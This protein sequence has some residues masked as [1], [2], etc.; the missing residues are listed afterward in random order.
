MYDV[1]SDNPS[2]PEQ[3]CCFSDQ[4]EFGGGSVLSTP[5]EGALSTQ[6][7]RVAKSTT[8]SDGAAKSTKTSKKSIFGLDLDE[9]EAVSFAMG[10]SPMDDAVGLPLGDDSA[11]SPNPTS[12]AAT[13]N[14]MTVYGLMKSG[15]MYAICPFIPHKSALSASILQNLHLLNTYAWKS[16]PS[17][18]PY[19][20][21]QFYWR[22]RWLEDALAQHAQ[23]Q[24]QRERLPSD[25]VLVQ[26]SRSLSAR[27]VPERQGP[28]LV[29]PERREEAEDG[30]ERVWSDLAVVSGADGASVLI[31]AVDDA[32]TVDVG[33]ELSSPLPQWEMAEVESA[34]ANLPSSLFP[35][36]QIKLVDI[37]KPQP[38]V[39]TSPPFKFS[40]D[41]KY[42]DVLY[43]VHAAGVHLLS[44]RAWFDKLAFAI[45][46][47][48]AELASLLT[49][50]HVDTEVQSLVETLNAGG[51]E[52]AS[53]AVVNDVILGYFF[54]AST[55]SND[56]VGGTLTLRPHTTAFPAPV[57]S[58]A[59]V[60]SSLKIGAYRPS[61]KAAFEI[62]KAFTEMQP[63]IARG[64]GDTPLDDALLRT[65]NTKTAG[66][67]TSIGN[68]KSGS[69]D[70][71]NRLEDIQTEAISQHEHTQSYL[72]AL[73]PLAERSGALAKRME[74]LARRQEV[75]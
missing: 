17:A 8:T 63:V 30:K 50:E 1:S 20:E 65:L 60:K 2:E 31:V 43:V 41:P 25:R 16:N 18:D 11:T 27:L 69:F 40:K 4:S 24:Q 73:D 23:Q 74:V 35:Y 3:S 21:K 42:N 61:I 47:G 39:F 32:G 58:K 19:A 59:A 14:A 26:V 45:K 29:L 7:K 56:I 33:I 68:L 10:A 28:L 52:M 62:P 34:P 51:N 54:I 13:W 57:A 22:N 9:R 38:S 37:V 5:F 44:F 72:D 6:F 53:F 12:A 66:I 48:K 55:A 71:Q 64:D 67:R 46:A 75:L 70:L 15:D 49:G 36:E